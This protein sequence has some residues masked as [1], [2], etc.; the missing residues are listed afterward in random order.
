[1]VAIA[2]GYI[3]PV[4]PK[5]RPHR[6]GG[7]SPLFSPLSSAARI[8]SHLRVASART[9]VDYGELLER[10]AELGALRTAALDAARGT[11]RAIVV[12]GPAGIGKTALVGAARA[13]AQEARLHPLSARGSE[14][15]RA[16]GFGVVRQLLEPAVQVD[17]APELFAGSAAFAAP[18]L[19]V[20]IPGAPALPPGPEGA[21]AVLHG[22]YRFTANLATA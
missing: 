2:R 4:V 20:N 22:L 14:L 5:G 6:Y 12:E 15:E 19:G 13:F 11:G 3:H 1:M 9:A 18:L 8:C 17:D 16:F 7:G 10:H 21:A